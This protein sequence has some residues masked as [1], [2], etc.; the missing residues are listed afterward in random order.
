MNLKIIGTGS[1]GN[2]YLLQGENETLIIEAGVN[3]A[4]I[5]KAL[6]YNLSNVVGVLLS[7]AHT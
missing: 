6:N 1:K 3:F 2:C 7:H 5:K 4:D